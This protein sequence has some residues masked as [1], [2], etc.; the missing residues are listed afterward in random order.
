[1]RGSSP[2]SSA[3]KRDGSGANAARNATRAAEG[4][5]RRGGV[6]QDQENVPAGQS[7]RLGEI[8]F[9]DSRSLGASFSNELAERH[10]ASVADTGASAPGSPCRRSRPARC[11]WRTS[12][13]MGS[14]SAVMNLGIGV[15][16]GGRTGW[17]AWQHTF[18]VA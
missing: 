11:R 9:A 14:S 18:F 13:A 15:A 1:M 16:R 6:R 17:S 10:A 12:Q 8:K 4:G 5:P 7:V 2:A 3:A